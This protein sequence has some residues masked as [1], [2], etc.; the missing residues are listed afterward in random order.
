MTENPKL[1]LLPIDYR[2]QDYQLSRI[3]A[4]KA[5]VEVPDDWENPAVREIAYRDQDS[6]GTC[7]GQSGAYLADGIHVTLSGQKPT[8]GDLARFKKDVVDEHGTLHDVLYSWSASAEGFYQK[9]RQIGGITDADGEGTDTR[10]VANAWIKYGYVPE[11]MWH[12]A[13]TNKNIWLAPPNEEEAARFAAGHTAEGWAMVGDKYGI[14]SFDEIC[15]AIYKYGFVLAGIPVYSNYGKMKGGNGF[16][17]EPNGQIA[18]Y[19]AL[20][21]YGYSKTAGTIKL[22]HSWGDWCSQLGGITKNYFEYSADQSIYLVILDSTDTTIGEAIYRSLEII[23]KD[24]KTGTPLKAD[25]YIDGEKRGTSP[26][27]VAVEYGH[28][29]KVEVRCSGYKPLKQTYSC[30]SKKKKSSLLTLKLKQSGR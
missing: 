10:Y 17:P 16:F 4:L 9:S 20:C 13:K 22:L 15:E 19:H 30:T 27:K 24:S 28:K 29:Y 8:S 14:A 25:I 1:G 11:D 5:A 2:P 26:L 12:T 6:R 21:F 23:V 18:G 3:Q 7:G